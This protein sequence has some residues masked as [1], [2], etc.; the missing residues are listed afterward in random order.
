MDKS[1]ECETESRILKGLMELE[2]VFSFSDV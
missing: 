2:A 1:M